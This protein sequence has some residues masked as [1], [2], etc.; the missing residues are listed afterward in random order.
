MQGTTIQIA[1][2][3]AAGY[4]A[5]GGGADDTAGAGTDRRTRGALRRRRRSI[6]A[7]DPPRDQPTP[8]ALG[9]SWTPSPE[10]PQLDA[11]VDGARALVAP[12]AGPD[13]EGGGQRFERR[14]RAQD[15]PQA[16]DGNANR[17]RRLLIHDAFN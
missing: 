10:R 14:P 13:A 5:G 8:A 15:P 7:R 4:V 9:P 12:S 11:L 1:P 2:G 6:M 3:R 17:S 16:G